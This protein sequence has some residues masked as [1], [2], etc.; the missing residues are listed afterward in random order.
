[1]TIFN[2][3]KSFLKVALIFFVL[4]CHVKVHVYMYLSISLKLD[5]T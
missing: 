1:M 5:A 4:D 3:G 2:F